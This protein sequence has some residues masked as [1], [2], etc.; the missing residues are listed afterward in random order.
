MG[1]LTRNMLRVASQRGVDKDQAILERMYMFGGD[2]GVSPASS[3]RV[4]STGS[5]RATPEIAAITGGSNGSNGSPVSSQLPP[6]GPGSPGRW[7]QGAAPAPGSV[8]A[9]KQNTLA[10]A[11]VEE[12]DLEIEVRPRP[13]PLFL[14]ARFTGR[15]AVPRRR[16][17]LKSP[18]GGTMTGP[19]VP[20]TTSEHPPPPPPPP[21]PP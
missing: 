3:P 11:P 20:T 21:P 1:S 16:L 15:G 19:T 4:G 17:T 14:I 12:E 9:V 6:A 7:P 5:E 13:N 8:G 10:P 2:G 18:T